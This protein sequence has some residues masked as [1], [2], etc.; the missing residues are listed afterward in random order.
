[1]A[2]A[3]SRTTAL[4][5]P[6]DPHTGADLLTDNQKSRIEKLFATDD[7]AQVEVTWNIYQRMIRPYRNPTRA[8]GKN[9]MQTLTDSMRTGVPAA[10]T[11]VR[12]LRS[13]LHCR[14]ADVTA[15]LDRPG[16][17]YG[18]TEAINGRLERLRG[19][20]LGCGNLTNDIARS[21]LRQLVRA[22][23]VAMPS[24]VVRSG[25]LTPANRDGKTRVVLRPGPTR[26]AALCTAIP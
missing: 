22:E 9:A 5:D 2:T 14:A 23:R 17:S 1:M 25:G 11:E 24:I 18:P 3:D 21:P 4:Q 10:L 20:A 13:T 15:Y 19:S 7:H 26:D 6:T 8:R 16:T 12:R